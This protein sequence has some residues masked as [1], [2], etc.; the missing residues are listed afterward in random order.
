MLVYACMYVLCMYTCVCM[1][2]VC[3]CVCVRVRVRLWVCV[4]AF[5]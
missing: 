1:Y 3:V 2:V 4:V 5:L